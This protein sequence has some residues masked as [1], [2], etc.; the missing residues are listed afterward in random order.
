MTKLNK[1]TSIEGI[2]RKKEIKRMRIEIKNK[3]NN[4]L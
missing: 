3:T 4:K 2:R 1:T